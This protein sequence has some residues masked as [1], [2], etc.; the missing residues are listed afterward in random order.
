MLAINLS[1]RQFERDDLPD[2]IGRALSESGR[3]PGSVELKIT[4]RMLM[5]DSNQNRAS[6][7]RMRNLGVSL[8]IDDF[9]VGFSSLSYISRFSVN[10]IK[11]DRSFIQRCTNDDNGLVVVRAIVAMAHGLRIQVVAEGIETAEQLDVLKRERCDAA[12]GYYI[13]RPVPAANLSAL[14]RTAEE[15]CTIGLERLHEAGTSA[16]SPASWRAIRRRAS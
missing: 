8:A 5:T 9:G 16:V 1:P 10:R 3:S 13:G 11:I 15:T 2:M 12:Q 14:L 7:M 4:E 6:L